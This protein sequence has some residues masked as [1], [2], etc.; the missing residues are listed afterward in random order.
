MALTSRLNKIFLITSVFKACNFQ[1]TQDLQVV[2]FVF[3]AFIFHS[4]KIEDNEM[5]DNL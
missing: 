1:S 3:T 2:V 5:Q 4:A